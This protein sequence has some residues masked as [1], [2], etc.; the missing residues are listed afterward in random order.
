MIIYCMIIPCKELH[1]RLKIWFELLVLWGILSSDPAVSDL[2]MHVYYNFYQILK[3]NL[4]YLIDRN[5]LGNL[6]KHQCP[7]LISKTS[8][9]LPVYQKTFAVLNTCPDD[10]LHRLGF[11]HA[12]KLS[13]FESSLNS[14]S[15]QYNHFGNKYWNMENK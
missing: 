5:T 13:Q 4:F 11:S 14:I 10:V 1:W 8:A 7:I 2:N 12:W 6:T 15:K 9:L 3:P